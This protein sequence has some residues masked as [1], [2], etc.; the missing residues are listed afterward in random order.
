MNRWPTLKMLFLCGATLLTQ[1]V[2][3]KESDY[4]QQEVDYRIQVTLDDQTHRLY[5]FLDLTYKNNS[6]DTLREIYFHLWPNAYRNNET[7]LAKQLVRNFN[8]KFQFAP[9]SLRGGIDGLN[10][11]DRNG[12]LQWEYHPEHLDICLVTLK[13]PLAPGGTTTIRTPFEVKLP[14]DFSR[15]GHVGQ[16]YQISQWYPKPAV[17]DRE[18]WHAMPY[19]DLGEFYSEYG[20]FEVKIT[21]PAQYRVAAT[22]VLQEEEERN[23]LEALAQHSNILGPGEVS[24]LDKT[25][26]GKEKTITY[27]QDRIH[28]FAFFCSKSYLVRKEAATLEDGVTIDAWAFFEPNPSS[29]WFNGAFYVKRA[30]EAYSKW[31]GPYPYAHATAVEGA[32]SAG[33]GMEYPMVTVISAGGDS[34]SLDNVITHE[35]G[36][37]WF[38]GI[39]GSNEREHAW[40][41]E[42]FNSYV[43]GRYM[44]TY[45]PDRVFKDQVGLPS[46]IK[47]DY[48]AQWFDYLSANILSSY[49]LQMKINTPSEEMNFL[50]YGLL[51]YK[52]T[53]F[54]LDYLS[55]YL[56]QETFDSCMHQYFEEWKFKHPRPQDLKAV[57]EKVS[58]Q[59]LSW[60]FDEYIDTEKQADY[61]IKKVQQTK[62]GYR[63][64]VKNKGEIAAPLLLQAISKE[65]TTTY[66]IKGLSGTQ[67][68]PL[69]SNNVGNVVI[70][71]A[72][73]SPDLDLRHHQAKTRGLFKKA[74]P[75]RVGWLTNFS[76]NDKKNLFITPLLGVN[77]SDG[78]LAGA[79]IH[80]FSIQGKRFN[81]LLMPMYGVSS[82]TLAGNFF[83]KYDWFV[84]DRSLNKIRW[85][86]QYK[87][88]AGY[89]KLET[90]LNF[91][92][93]TGG[94]EHHK[95]HLMFSVAN[96]QHRD[97]A[98][99]MKH[100]MNTVRLNYQRIRKNALV[101]ER[102]DIGFRYT[103]VFDWIEFLRMEAFYSRSK[104][105]TPKSFIVAKFYGG[106]NIHSRWGT[107]PI[108]S[109]SSPDWAK[110]AY[111]LDRVGN[112]K[113]GWLGRNQVLLDQGQVPGANFEG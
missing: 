6:L 43:E 3:G 30:I 85:T 97:A 83:M 59:D 8:H 39:L 41:D 73:Q 32:L 87:R 72:Y 78:L 11:Q 84:R 98:Y 29:P 53:A 5:G 75:I 45:Y 47:M 81:Y 21:L 88:F 36:H 1:W 92:F 104:R 82:N 23:W 16:S 28:D 71:L 110:D 12:P 96:I 60:F 50:Q 42:G 9:D 103:A 57:F 18:G 35:V 17:Y 102:F 38:Y 94:K 58:G 48:P 77:T 46:F 101:K 54:L 14:G 113:A 24:L 70:D 51:A 37:N 27:K 20:S 7:A 66:R 99:H 2:T 63:V 25:R 95:N 22:G 74:Q 4:F 52:R 100:N 19:L 106:M 55:V 64:K 49:G 112:G 67:W 61:L 109:A 93:G 40:M 56:G 86:G 80:N 15:M 90:S 44:R 33:G 105:I 65:D 34:M 108:Y 76:R 79:A 31:V 107:I 89:D 13:S 68:I 91:F 62:T 111:L 69:K 10:F 26:E